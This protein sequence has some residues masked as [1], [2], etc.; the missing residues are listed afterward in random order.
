M[1][2]LRGFEPHLHPRTESSGVVWGGPSPPVLARRV[3]CPLSRGLRWRRPR[4][5]GSSRWGGDESSPGPRH[6]ARSVGV[7]TCGSLDQN[8]VTYPDCLRLWC[9]VW[10]VHNWHNGAAWAT[11]ERGSSDRARC[12]SARAVES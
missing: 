11:L 12:E 9:P 5:A 7:G 6:H 4:G 2:L 3:G 8:A 10:H 1:M